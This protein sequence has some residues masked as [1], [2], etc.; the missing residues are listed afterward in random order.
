MFLLDLMCNLPRLK[1]S[2]SQVRA[3]LFVMR[4]LGLE[5]IPSLET[6]RR[7]QKEI[8]QRVS[9]PYRKSESSRNN[10]YYTLELKEQVAQDLANPRLR[11]FLEIYP[12]DKQGFVGESWQ[13]SK[14]LNE[15]DPGMVPPMAEGL[16]EQ[17][18]YINE[19]A[20]CLN[21][22]WAIPLRWVKRNGILTCDAHEVDRVSFNLYQCK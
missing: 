9:I 16:G 18:F 20:L 17:H 19:L 15:T 21:G 4:E 14:W 12:E 5:K 6:L 13:A 2:D 8:N 22:S 3:V 7:V 11:P 1:M 10:I